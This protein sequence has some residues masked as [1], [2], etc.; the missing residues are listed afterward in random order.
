MSA[1]GALKRAAFF[2][3]L[4]IGLAAP[5][6]ANA[7][8]VG[9]DDFNVSKNGFVLMNDPFDD[10]IP[11]GGPGL[12]NAG[13]FPPGTQALYGT[14]GN[15]GQAETGSNRVINTTLVPSIPS[16]FSP[17]EFIRP[18]GGTLLTNTQ[19]LSV[20][21][22][23]LKRDDT[24]EVQGVF[25]LVDPGTPL[26][27]YGIR[28]RDRVSFANP[29][30]DELRMEV[31]K[32]PGG[33]VQV[34]F[35][36]VDQSAGGIFT[37]IQS[38]VLTALQLATH[39]QIMLSLAKLNTGSDTI[40]ASFELLNGGVGSGLQ[41]FNIAN[42]VRDIFDGEDWTQ[43]GFRALERV[44]PQPVDEPGMLALFGLAAGGLVWR[45][46]RQKSSA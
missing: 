24:F 28:L 43:A 41:T 14:F 5:L 35:R 36:Y 42:P 18:V 21:T 34:A 6:S 22:F 32:S 2:S 33:D 45:R 12:G 37:P 3:A 1:L 9:L 4:S 44:I 10:N 16:T 38:V 46:T 15:S 29:G 20:S 25:D 19:P 17:G 39:D 7:L 40:T 27:S 30:N 13:L 11:F 26:S 8:V 31:R 23:G